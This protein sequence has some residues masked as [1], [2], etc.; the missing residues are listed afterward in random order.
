MGSKALIAMID[1]YVNPTG[2]VLGGDALGDGGGGA[3]GDSSSLANG[4][5]ADYRDVTLN[6]AETLINVNFKTSLALKR[7]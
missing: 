5:K 6:T 3:S 7:F 4:G 2:A 1:I